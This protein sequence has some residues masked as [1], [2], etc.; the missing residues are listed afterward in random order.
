VGSKRKLE[1]EVAGF[2]GETISDRSGQ[3]ATSLDS[4]AALLC[5]ALLSPLEEETDAPRMVD[6]DFLDLDPSAAL[7]RGR[8]C[9]TDS[10]PLPP[11][12]ILQKLL[13]LQ[14]CVRGI[15]LY[16]GIHIEKAFGV[17]IVFRWKSREARLAHYVKQRGRLL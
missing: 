17:T 11:G 3:H 1:E 9:D 16:T 13:T 10:L 6:E 5:S 2:F 8:W 4:L 7:E 14:R 15:S 12:S